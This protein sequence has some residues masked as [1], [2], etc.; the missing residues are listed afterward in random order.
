[1][2]GRNLDVFV[3]S[4]YI[5]FNYRASAFERAVEQTR[6]LIET[7]RAARVRKI[8]H[9]SVSNADERSDL[10]YTRQPLRHG[11]DFRDWLGP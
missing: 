5:R 9:G 6:V 11:G 2:V 1:M 8:V 3:N 4:Y 10:P 7:A